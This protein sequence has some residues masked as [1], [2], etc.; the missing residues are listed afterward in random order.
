MSFLRIKK[1]KKKRSH[2]HWVLTWDLSLPSGWAH[3]QQTP[4]FDF[5]PQSLASP[6]LPV[7]LRCWSGY[8][9]T[10]LVPFENSSA[11]TITRGP[12]LP[13]LLIRMLGCCSEVSKSCHLALLSQV[14]ATGAIHTSPPH[15]LPPSALDATGFALADELPD[16]GGGC[17]WQCAF[18]QKDS[19]LSPCSF[20]GFRSRLC[21]WRKLY[22]D[23]E[24]LLLSP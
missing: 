23:Q 19:I 2:K 13:W 12:W 21:W 4:C 20:C 22:K 11:E 5:L 16:N 24:Q 7:T 6:G 17:L 8:R 18:V 15:H 9:V 3:Q 10:W 14:Q 1:E